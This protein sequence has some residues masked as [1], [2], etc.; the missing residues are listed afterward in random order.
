MGDAGVW[1]TLQFKWIGIQ[2]PVVS[3]AFEKLL[4]AGCIP[5]SMVVLTW[6]AVAAVGAD[7]AAYYLAGVLIA[8]YRLFS[9]PLR[10]S[11]Y[12]TDRGKTAV[13]EGP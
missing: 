10:S 13:G 12:A 2:Y 7:Q 3:V 5:A 4:I 6:G 9:I 8:S 1:A 11:F